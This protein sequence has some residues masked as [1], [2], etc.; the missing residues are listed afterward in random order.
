MLVQIDGCN[1][2]TC[3]CGQNFCHLCGAGDSGWSNDDCYVHMSMMHGG[4][5]EA[6]VEEE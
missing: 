2:I 4:I 3:I 1:H 6:E 5:F